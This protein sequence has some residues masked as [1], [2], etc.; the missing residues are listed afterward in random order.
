MKKSIYL[1]IVLQLLSLGVMS[2]VSLHNLLT[3]NKN[4]PIGLDITQPR[5][6][7]QLVSEKRNIKQT[8][9]EVK[10]TSGKNIL[11]NSGKV[12]SDQ[13]VQVTY[14]GNALQSGV[15]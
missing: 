4:N 7:W 11:W 3:E 1:I 8:A 15:K 14:A 5:F 10:V 13:S 6:T 9:Y 12:L 2:Q